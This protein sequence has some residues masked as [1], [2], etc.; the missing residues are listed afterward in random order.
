MPMR[1]KDLV[2]KHYFIG[3]GLVMSYLRNPLGPTKPKIIFVGV[4]TSLPLVLWRRTR[5]S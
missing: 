2:A 3:I 4:S 5:V 1:N